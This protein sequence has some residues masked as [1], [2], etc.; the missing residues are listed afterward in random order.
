MVQ[1]AR[2]DKQPRSAAQI[3]P[4]GISF[5]L[6]LFISLWC[7][8]DA[9]IKQLEFSRSDYLDITSNWLT[10]P[11]VLADMAEREYLTGDPLKARALYIRALDSFVL[12]FPSWLGLAEV[13]NDQKKTAQASAVLQTLENFSV[14]K[15]AYLWRLTHL[16]RKLN[17]DKILLSALKALL[18]KD[19]KQ[20]DKIF[21]IAGSYFQEPQY[22]I[23]NFNS[24]YYPQILDYYIRENRPEAVR[25][26]WAAMEKNS[27]LPSRSVIAYTA[28]LLRT[29]DFDRA[30]K[31]WSKTFQK[32]GKFL[33]N[34]DFEKPII[35][36]SFGWQATDTKSVS[37]HYDEIGG[38]TIQFAGTEN[39]AYMLSQIVPLYPGDHIFRGYFETTALTSGERPYFQ[40]SG[41]NCQ[42]L[43]IQDTML[44]PS[45]YKTEFAIPFH[46]PDFCRAAKIDLIRK[47]ANPSDSLISGS[48]T[49]TDLQINRLSPIPIKFVEEEILESQPSAEPAR[50]PQP[51][52]QKPVPPQAIKATDTK[53]TTRTTTVAKEP[54]PAQLQPTA[55]PEAKKKTILARN[56]AATEDTKPDIYI[57]NDIKP[58]TTINIKRLIIR[59]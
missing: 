45:E 59:E 22:L 9:A 20:E 5:L 18:V 3:I 4:Q 31:I 2:T 56:Q 15:P 50:Q 21:N 19:A 35:D 49:L 33:Y 58:K 25:K 16:A 6:I 26:V 11:D 38:L 42:D 10:N 37:L 53:P 46:L 51:A 55:K 27:I 29:N 30:A 24:R 39:T 54:Q 23:R 28:F 17:Q 48:V 14:E 36:T 1:A 8:K 7:L 34:G 57:P 13:L 52:V 32:D 43:Y 47:K 41:Y 40:I 44:P 12:H